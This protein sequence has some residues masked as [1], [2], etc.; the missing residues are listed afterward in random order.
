MLACHDCDSLY[1]RP[2][3]KPGQKARCTRCGAV[4]L[5]NKPNGI[6]RCLALNVANLVLL[7]L[8]NVFPLMTMNIQ[9]RV[10]EA[11]VVSG[12]I[13]LYRQGFGAMAAVVLMVSVLA[14]ALK[15]LCTLYVLAPLRFNRALPHA[16]RVFRTVANLSPWSMTEVF[17]LGILVALVKLAD[18]ARLAPGLAMFSFIALIVSM[19]AADSALEPDEVWQRLDPRA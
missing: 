10:Q 6:E 1:P 8:A 5:E 18:L 7:I 14:P 3:L 16:T 9:G 15:I 4:L 13:E 17:M 2:R 11:N 19:A 12:V